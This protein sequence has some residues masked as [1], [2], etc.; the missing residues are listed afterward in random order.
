MSVK[1]VKSL[2]SSCFALA[3]RFLRM[4]KDILSRSDS[5][6]R[7]SLYKRTKYECKSSYHF[8]DSVALTG[9]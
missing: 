3:C 1:Y 2:M 4:T 9:A 7:V 6:M 8:S 5:I